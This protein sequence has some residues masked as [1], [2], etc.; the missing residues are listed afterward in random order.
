MTNDQINETLDQ[1]RGELCLCG[2]PT[3]NHDMV[4]GA[5]LA[6]QECACPQYGDEFDGVW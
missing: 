4:D 5:V 6:C 3:G 1:H 2:H